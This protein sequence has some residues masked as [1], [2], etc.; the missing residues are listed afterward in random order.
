MFRLAL[1]G[2]FIGLGIVAGMFLLGM[3][4]RWRGR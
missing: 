4:S 1:I 3:V 2:F